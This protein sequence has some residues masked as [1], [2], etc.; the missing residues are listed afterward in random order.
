MRTGS[1]ERFYGQQAEADQAFYDD[2]YLNA[3]N[4]TH[5]GYKYINSGGFIGYAGVLTRMV[6]EA[7][8]IHPGAEGWRK[9]TCGEAR[10]RVCA[11]MWIYGHLVAHTW[12]KYN[13]SLDYLR[14]IFYVASGFDWALDFAKQ[15]IALSQPCV[16]HMPFMQAPHVN[17]RAPKGSNPCSP[18]TALKAVPSSAFRLARPPW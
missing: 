13:A 9:K 17:V 6:S 10:G 15:R 1:V 2:S 7:L 4:E 11:D 18:S 12:N 14:S 8:T 5:G 3:T 16:V